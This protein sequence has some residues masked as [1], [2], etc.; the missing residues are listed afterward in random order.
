MAKV[1]TNFCKPSDDGK[2]IIFAPVL[3]PPKLTPPT[4]E[5]YNEHGWYRNAVFPPSPPEGK[6]LASTTYVVEDNQVVAEYEYEDAPVPVRTFSK[7]K[8]YGA[9]VQLGLWDNIETWLKGQTIHGV[10][11]YTAFMMAQDLN[12]QNPMFH[13]CYEAVKQVLGIDDQTAEAILNSAIAD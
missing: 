6:V 3:I 12:D 7:L 9:L 11:A 1:N 5:E 10:N 13:D 4:E 2:S 8:L